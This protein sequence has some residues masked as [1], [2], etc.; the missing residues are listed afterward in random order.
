[1]RMVKW[2]GRKCMCGHKHCKACMSI[3]PKHDCKIVLKDRE[4]I[5]YA[6]REKMEKNFQDNWITKMLKNKEK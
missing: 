3:D 6:Y 5:D 4:E 1:M 2:T